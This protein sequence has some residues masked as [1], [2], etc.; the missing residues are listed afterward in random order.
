MA[1]SLVSLSLHEP[2]KNVIE[3]TGCASKFLNPNFNEW[4]DYDDRTPNIVNA[5]IGEF[6]SDSLP[7]NIERET[8]QRARN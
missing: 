7:R 1:E 8:R 2:I 6:N 5:M 4:E 3:L